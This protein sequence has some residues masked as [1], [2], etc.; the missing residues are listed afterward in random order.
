[1]SGKLFGYARVSTEDQCLDRQIDILQEYGVTQEDI[2][3]DKISGTKFS[4]PQFD[5][6]KK[7]LRTGDTVITESLSR[8]SRS[9]ADL[10]NILNEWADKGITY[11]SIKEQIDFSTSTG[12]LMLTVLAALSQFERDVIRDRVCEGIS[13]ARARGR[14]GGRPRTDKKVLEKAIKLYE[15]KTYSISEIR[16][17][18]KVSSSVL[19]RAL[20]E[21]NKKN[22][23][24]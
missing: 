8:L 21:R 9:T 23:N 22:T 20:N 11:I 5:E 7:Q 17:I 1:M 6:L 16:E 15:A 24:I 3:A 2:F 12:K 4:R 18:T 19:Y 10:L 13:S 14:I